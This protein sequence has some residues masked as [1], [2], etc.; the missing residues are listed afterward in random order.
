MKTERKPFDYGVGALAVVVI[1]VGIAAM[2]YGLGLIPLDMVNILAWIFGPL[3]I[4]TIIYSVVG[5][6]DSTYYLVWGAVMIAIGIVTGF[7]NQ[8]T[9]VPVFGM[10]IIVLAVIGVIGYWRSRK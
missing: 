1:S 2:V 6:R 7:Y 4:Y 5:G 3:G 9:P 8:V 10:L